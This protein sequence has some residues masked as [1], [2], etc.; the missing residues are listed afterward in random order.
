[1]AE[2]KR[3]LSRA[4]LLTLSGPGGCGKTR[5]AIQV[6]ADLLERFADGVWL[7]E[8][9]ML[10]DMTLVPHA[11]AQALG[12]GE[13]PSQSMTETLV[14]Y[15]QHRE[16]LLVL[17]NCEHVIEAC[18]ELTQMLLRHCP[19]L[20]L[21]TTS[22]E[23]L[24]IAGETSWP[25]RPLSLPDAQDAGH[26]PS[27]EH[28]M[29]YEATRLFIERAATVLPTF[30]LTRSEDA[31]VITQVCY[32]L[33][34]IPLAI[35]LAAARVKMLSLQQVAVRLDD[36]F[37]LLTAGS[38]T[39]LPHQQTL[40]ATMDW[41]YDLLTAKERAVFRRLSV[42]VGG[43]T[44]EAAEE[45]CAGDTLEQAEV[46]DLLSHLVNK[47]LVV[48]EQHA[49]EP[50]YRLLESTRQYGKEKLQDNNEHVDTRRRHRDWYL[51]LAERAQ[52]KLKG[53]DQ[54]FWLDRLAM[55]HDNLRA[56]L[57]WTLFQGDR[58]T[59]LRLVT[60]V[61]D[62][63]SVHGYFSEGCRWLEMGLAN[64]ERLPLY[65]QAK[66]FN[67]MGLLIA[68]QGDYLQAST[69][70]EKSLALFQELEDSAGI[71][72][73]LHHLGYIAER[74]GNYIQARAL[75]QESL[76]LFREL[77]D[78]WGIALAAN[79]LGGIAGKQG[80]AEEIVRLYKES[81]AL[82]R[83]LGDMLGLAQS[84]HNLGYMY[85]KISDYALATTLLKESFELCQKLGDKRGMAI[86]LH[87][88]GCTAFEQCDFEQAQ[89]LLEEG[90]R[91]FWNVGDKATSAESLEELAG[92]AGARKQ[93]E[94]AARLWGAAEAIRASIDAPLEPFD[95]TFSMEKVTY[96]RIQA[97]EAS[98]AKSWAEGRAMSMEQAIAYALAQPSMPRD[99]EVQS[100][101]GG[102]ILIQA[103]A[104]PELRILSLGQMQVYRGDY[105]L[106]S[107][108][109]TYSKGR[110]LL[111]YLLCHRPKTK[112]QIGLALWPDASATQLRNNF[113][114]TLYHLR[115]ALGR[116]EWI[117]R[118][119]ECYAFNRQRSYW[120]DVEAFEHSLVEA[121]R[122]SAT[123]PA[124][125][126]QFLEEATNLY[127]GDFLEDLVG[128]DWLLLR[129][130]G[131]QRQ[132]LEALFTLGQRLF[133]QTRYPQAADAFRQ[134]IAYDSYHEAAHRELMRCH[135]RQ[136]ER[137][138][139][140][141]CYQTLLVQ[142][143]DGL[144]FAPN[145]ETTALFERLSRG[146]EL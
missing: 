110:E 69:Y 3:L 124:Q 57:Q 121:R 79:R 16:L 139:A 136:G 63:W 144:G 104:T 108:D 95:L 102:S 40:R 12:V 58:E 122:C 10:S 20:P 106:T 100:P 81:L 101:A 92:V 55:E 65:L 146:D 119:G 24:N 19:H 67:A 126:T 129:R 38:R 48:V 59:L 132:Y 44:L 6:A 86:A 114:V 27:L 39:E 123:S 77:E 97:D 31:L 50:R 62:F 9:A 71:A 91:L 42:F 90:L 94:R 21:L 118:D 13:L 82:R 138:Q 47:S 88:L 115:R 140:I 61:S 78:K 60:A 2:V 83:E 105:A 17:D 70:H 15:L 14:D 117:I 125:E 111:F 25:V 130:E 87:N 98:F 131:L 141:K 54:M 56:S 93:M 96:T 133:A 73:T 127:Q 103:R 66:A 22:R 143:Q 36:R 51:S 74:R 35:E 145:A 75:L 76:T 135:A 72:I 49:S 46:L 80:N 68:H 18:A 89:R 128:G 134:I 64:S 53:A 4:P 28:L 84:L 33:D 32:R 41:S 5:L 34:G 43:F 8:L 37:H 45:I 52:S 23:A 99:E 113:R 142:M 116:P 107:S 137:S 120:F 7:V 1:M 11:I 109:W 26:L 30:A 112:E 85:S 29:Q